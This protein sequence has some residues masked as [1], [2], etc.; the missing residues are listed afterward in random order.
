MLSS[1]PETEVEV[2]V[3][4]STRDSL[5][6]QLTGLRSLL[7]LNADGVGDDI[8][9]FAQL[10]F[11]RA[12]LD[13][14]AASLSQQKDED[15]EILAAETFES[16]PASLS[17]TA[18]SASTSPRLSLESLPSWQSSP[19]SQMSISPRRSLQKLNDA[20][21]ES[22]I[23][24]GLEGDVVT[25]QDDTFVR[26]SS[27]LASL[28][29]QAEA[30]V[31]APTTAQLKDA[32]SEHTEDDD[33]TA[34]GFTTLFKLPFNNRNHRKANSTPPIQNPN[35]NFNFTS[36]S[37]KSSADPPKLS[38]TTP[39]SPAFHRTQSMPFL[40]PRK[41]KRDPSTEEFYLP[42]STPTNPFRRRATTPQ[43]P[44]LVSACNTPSGMSTP[45]RSATFP[46]SRRGS[47]TLKD[48]ELEQLLV[49]FI[50]SR[51]REEDV[52]F[53][54]VWIYLMGGGLI[55][56]VVGWALKWNCECSVA[57]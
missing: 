6:D 40:P 30:A 5:V 21:N 16:R 4:E 43:D 45:I 49:E 17:M 34:L 39:I 54:W 56:F 12:A 20:D 24:D 22:A 57:A 7:R 33:M 36:N 42:P 10:T 52:M 26:L 14:F 27:L 3:V 44:R 2:D 13:R 41:H 18:S 47:S 31:S 19:T 23:E 25:T 50:E 48:F 15:D 1:T 46:R 29:A 9:L 37:S 35:T 51:N 32:D 55:Y 38:P 11:T 28:Q 8:D 53:K